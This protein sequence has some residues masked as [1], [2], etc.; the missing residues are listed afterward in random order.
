MIRSFKDKN[1]ERIWNQQHVKDFPAELHRT[2]HKRLLHLAAATNL[3]DL[4]IPPSNRLHALKGDR[5]GQHSISI[6]MQ[7][8]ICFRWEDGHAFDVELVDYH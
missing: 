2:A 8:R 5:L 1:T 3:L 7:Y 4:R 6:N